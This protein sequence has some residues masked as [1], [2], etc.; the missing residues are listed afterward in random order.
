MFNCLAAIRSSLSAGT[1]G[2]GCA[3]SFLNQRVTKGCLFKKYISKCLEY[4]IGVQ[5]G[6]TS[7][8]ELLCGYSACSLTT[9]NDAVAIG[10][11]RH[12]CSG[13]AMIDQVLVL[14]PKWKLF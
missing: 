8:C 13:G 9:S 3:K 12:L 11:A 10:S 1:G 14:V 5:C 4:E 7:T 6:E 2:T